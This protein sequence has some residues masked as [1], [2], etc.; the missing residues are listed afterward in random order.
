MSDGFPA[1]DAFIPWSTFAFS[2]TGCGVAPFLKGG[3]HRWE[4]KVI[5]PDCAVPWGQL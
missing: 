5:N 1:H 3:V 2:L 4:P